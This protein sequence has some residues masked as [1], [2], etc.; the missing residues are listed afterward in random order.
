MAWCLDFAA[1]A[2]AGSV[3]QSERFRFSV[4]QRARVGSGIQCYLGLKLMGNDNRSPTWLRSHT[5]SG[6]ASDSAMSLRA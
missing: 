2:T 5:L 6:D 4:V 3:D 1:S